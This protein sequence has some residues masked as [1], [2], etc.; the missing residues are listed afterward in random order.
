MALTEPAT[1]VLTALVGQPHHGYALIAQVEELSEGRTRLSVGT[2]YGLL[3][4]LS[5]EG[6]IALDRE[7]RH[8]GRT[9]R[10]YRLT[11]DGAA[12]LDAEAQRLAHLA[13][14]ASARLRAARAV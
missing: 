2:L 10:Y 6:L 1:L 4:R 9:R 14:A 5:S 11:D 8:A 7:E 12:A 13:R 3:D